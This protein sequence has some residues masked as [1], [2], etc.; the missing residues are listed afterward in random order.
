M[1]APHFIE[2]VPTHSAKHKPLAEALADLRRHIAAQGYSDREFSIKTLRIV[3]SGRLTCTPDRDGIQPRGLA[4][5]RRALQHVAELS[6]ADRP[7]FWV[8]NVLYCA[9]HRRG[10]GSFAE[11][12]ERAEPRADVIGRLAVDE[13]GSPYLRAVISDRHAGAAG[14]DSVLA[15]ILGD[16]VPAAYSG[17]ALAID[18]HADGSV[19]NWSVLLDTL[20]TSVGARRSL[21]VTNSETKATSFK[22]RHGVHLTATNTG[23]A[24]PVGFDLTSATARHIARGDVAHAMSAQVEA[25]LCSTIDLAAMIRARSET[26]LPLRST[27]AVAV[28]LSRRIALHGHDVIEGESSSLPSEGY[29]RELLDADESHS[30]GI[31]SIPHGTEIRAVAALSVVASKANLYNRGWLED[32]AGRLLSTGFKPGELA[33]AQYEID[34]RNK[35]TGLANGASPVVG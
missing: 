3:A 23:V 31:G 9:P 10:L 22:A 5:T 18:R 27:A 12:V 26:D 35:S 13:N 6:G 29:L 32:V 24:L 2:T 8:A 16:M 21:R 15:T 34:E 1:S 7:K 4:Y 33:S 28:A 19:S 14:D 30:S 25:A 11:L 17:A 20:A